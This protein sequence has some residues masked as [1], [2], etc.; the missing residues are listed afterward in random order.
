[1]CDVPSYYYYYYYYKSNGLP[2]FLVRVARPKPVM[3]VCEFT[4]PLRM[5]DLNGL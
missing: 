5:S 1:M 2:Q 3:C 4:S